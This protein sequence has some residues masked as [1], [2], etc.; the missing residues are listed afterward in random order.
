MNA[1]LAVFL[2]AAPASADALRQQIRTLEAQAEA[3]P[4]DVRPWKGLAVAWRR[5]ARLS[6]DAACDD[7]AW[8]A[9]GVALRVDPHDY[10]ALALKGWV[11]AARHDF[12]GA[13]VSARAAIAARPSDAWN[14][15]VLTDALTELGRYGE[16]VAAVDRMM[17]LRPGVG[18]YTRAA[19]LRALHGDREGAIELMKMAVEASGPSDRE[20]LAWCRVMLGLEYHARGDHDLARAQYRRALDVVPGYH[21]AVFHLAESLAATGELDAAVETL[22]AAQ[23]SAAVAAALGDLHQAAGRP[24]AAA[25]FYRQ[26]DAVAALKDPSR[27]EPRWLARFYADQGRNVDEAVALVRAELKTHQ[28]VETWDG[29]AWALHAAGRYDEARDASDKALAPGI[30]DARL[31]YHR[32]LIEAAL[33]RPQAA[34][35]ALEQALALHSLGPLER[36]RAEVALDGLESSKISW[37]PGSRKVSPPSS[38]RSATRASGRRNGRSSGTRAPRSASPA[39]TSPS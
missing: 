25:S 5:L 27:A 29:L 32:G 22:R 26:V 30:V 37:T 28:D 34:R 38:A 14:H 10:E 11:Q 31:L 9:L 3:R 8:D 20:G 39:A 13:V 18:S 4:S 24:A 17:R 12:E 19:H 35:A 1:L 21:L 2:M 16:A 36:T 15:G 23:P 6:G 7:K 33:A